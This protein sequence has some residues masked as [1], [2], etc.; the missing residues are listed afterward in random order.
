MAKL[1]FV[2]RNGQIF[3][4]NPDKVK[5][6]ECAFIVVKRKNEI[7]C[8]C[9]KI[10]EMYTIPMQE[11]VS[12]DSEPTDEFETTVYVIREDVPVKERQIYKIYEVEDVD[13]E[14]T[15]LAW[16]SLSDIL[17]DE[18]IFDATLKSGMKNLFVRGK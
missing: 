16:V 1:P 7:L 11:E 13:A 17:F 6:T 10:A 18:V 9:D 8:M 4:H 2:N 15:P 5:T 14:D 12:L 3:Y